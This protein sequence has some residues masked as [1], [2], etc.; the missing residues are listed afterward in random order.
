MKLYHSVMIGIFMAYIG[1]L[2]VL[3]VSEVVTKI[4]NYFNRPLNGQT[5]TMRNDGDFS[6]GEVHKQDRKGGREA[7]K[8]KVNSFGNGRKILKT[9]QRLLEKIGLRKR[10][11]SGIN[12]YKKKK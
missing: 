8:E 3:G 6:D 9:F 10:K 7:T 5:T 4:R 2:A 12:E 1:F 11:L